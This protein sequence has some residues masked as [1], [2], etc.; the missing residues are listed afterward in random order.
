[1]ISLSVEKNVVTLSVLGEFTLDDFRQFEEHVLYAAKLGPVTLL[2]DLRDMVGYT[3]DVVWEEIKF[4]RE[5]QYD[6]DKIA[7][8]TDSQWVAWSAWLQR[9]FVDA[10]IEVFDDYDEARAWVCS[11]T[12]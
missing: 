5:H 9:I 1:M 2:I 11:D 4:S 8:V 12:G 3:L 6:F 7:V 10:D